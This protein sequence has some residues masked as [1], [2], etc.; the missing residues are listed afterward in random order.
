MYIKF[1]IWKRVIW[2]V[3]V[4]VGRNGDY[5][6]IPPHTVA[7]SPTQVGDSLTKVGNLLLL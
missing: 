2:R 5:V 7:G 4:C 1:N 6:P 3:M